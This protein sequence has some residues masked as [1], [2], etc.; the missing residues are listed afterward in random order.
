EGGALKVLDFG[1]ARLRQSA[2]SVTTTRTGDSMGT[3]AFMPPEQALGDWDAVDARSD[4]WAV[5]ATMFTLLTGR[6]V[7][8]ADNVQ[9]MMLASMTRPAPAL[10]SIDQTL[11][12]ELG[13]LVDRALMQK[14]SDC[15]P[16]A[17]SM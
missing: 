14:P 4:L 3:P 6:F 13:E 17:R 12:K 7:H 15:F 16:D 10:L 2:T 11:P 5:G 9:K 8:E 1:I